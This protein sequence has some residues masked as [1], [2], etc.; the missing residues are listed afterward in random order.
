MTAVDAL[1][2]NGGWGKASAV[3][4]NRKERQYDGYEPYYPKDRPDGLL[5]FF[6]VLFK[7]VSHFDL[8]CQNAHLGWLHT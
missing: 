2:G 7:F 8:Q 1:A 4:I 5:G 3:L 6:S